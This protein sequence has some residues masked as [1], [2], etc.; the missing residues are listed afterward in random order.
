MR[1]WTAVTGFQRSYRLGDTAL[2]DAAS[3]RRLARIIEAG[4]AAQQRLD[5]N[6]NSGEGGLSAAEVARLR[7]AAGKGLQATNQFMCANTRLVE[8]LL[9]KR[10]IPASVD[11]SDL[12]QEGC[13]AL[14]TAIIKFD[15]RKNFKFSTYATW[16]IKLAISESVR[17]QTGQLSGASLI[18]SQALTVK[19]LCTETAAYYGPDGIPDVDIA[20]IMRISVERLNTIRAW[21]SQVLSLDQPVGVDVEEGAL[22]LG[23]TLTDRRASAAFEQVLDDDVAVLVRAMLAGLP[24]RERDALQRQMAGRLPMSGRTAKEQRNAAARG[25]SRLRHP[26]SPHAAQMVGVLQ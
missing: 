13:L 10:C 4:R 25:M 9:N 18:E 14:H 6:A 17:H 7:A 8:Y 11:R 12:F 5:D 26:S 3:E 2:L 1:L 23:D 22:T 15:W 20:A 16:W 21:N 24:S 19:K